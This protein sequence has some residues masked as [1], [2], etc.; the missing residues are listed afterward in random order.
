MVPFTVTAQGPCGIN[1][2]FNAPSGAV[3]WVHTHPFRNGE[4][5]TICGAV[6]QPDPSAPGGYRDVIGPN[7]QPVYPQYRNN[8]SIP[9][10]E[11]MNDINATMALLGRNWL[12][13][14]I[15][16]ANQTTVYS[17]N[18]SEGTSPLPRCGY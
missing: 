9:D 5:Q 6:K 17:E 18:A 8:P 1:G 7:G 14:V 16:D 2:N 3:A 4:V 13:G 10:R 12:A 11:L 15:I